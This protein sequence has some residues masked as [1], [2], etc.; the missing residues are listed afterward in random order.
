MATVRELLDVGVGAAARVRLG[1]ARA[2][3]PS[4]CSRHVLGIDRTGVIANSEAPV[5]DGAA[6]RF[7]AS[8]STRRAAGEPVAYIRGVKEFHGLAFA[9]DD[10]AR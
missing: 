2:W 4:C 7:P 10:R 8:R 1:D 5:G 6:E 9:T 3:T